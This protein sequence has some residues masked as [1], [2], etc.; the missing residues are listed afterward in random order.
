MAGGFVRPRL[1]V[2]VFDRIVAHGTG[3]GQNFRGELP[4]NAHSTSD[5]AHDQRV[6]GLHELDLPSFADPH[7]FQSHGFA[8]IDANAV[9]EEDGP[10]RSA[11]QR[12]RIVFVHGGREEG[13]IVAGEFASEAGV[14]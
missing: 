11:G 4:R 14:R 3:G 5:D 9:D 12:L 10:A 2:G 7:A 6:A 1:L 8:A 13:V